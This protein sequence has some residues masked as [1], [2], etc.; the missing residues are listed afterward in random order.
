MSCMSHAGYCLRRACAVDR[1]MWLLLRSRGVTCSL[2]CMFLHV[3]VLT[4]VVKSCSGTACASGF[5]LLGEGG[6]M[7]ELTEL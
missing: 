1:S 5:Y 2:L 3:A 6:P 4:R 7:V